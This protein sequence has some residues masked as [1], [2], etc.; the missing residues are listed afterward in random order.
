MDTLHSEECA[1]S[2][3]PTGVMQFGSHYTLFRQDRTTN[4]RSEIAKANSSERSV[5]T[6]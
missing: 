3:Y 4:V 6:S 1:V 5:C 2:D